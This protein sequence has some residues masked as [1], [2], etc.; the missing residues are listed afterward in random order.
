MAETKPTPR[1]QLVDLSTAASNI[2]PL[3]FGSPKQ[4]KTSSVTQQ[5][6]IDPLARESLM[7]IINTSVSRANNPQEANAVVQDILRRASTAFA[8]VMGESNRTGLY[9]S[10]TL[11]LLRDQAVADAT[12]AGAKAVLDFQTQNQQI[13]ANAAG[14]LAQTTRSVNSQSTENG[15][16]APGIDPAVSLGI[17]GAIAAKTIWN[18]RGEIEDFISGAFGG[19]GSPGGSGSQGASVNSQEAAS[20]ID[21]EADLSPGNFDSEFSSLDNP[22]NFNAFSPTAF[23]SIDTPVGSIGVNPGSVLGAINTVAQS[24]AIGVLGTGFNVAANF[25]NYDPITAAAK[26][27]APFA[28]QAL[29]PGPLGMALNFAVQKGINYISNQFRTRGPFEKELEEYTP[30]DNYE[31][32]VGNYQGSFAGLDGFATAGA[33]GI[34]GQLANDPFGASPASLGINT[35]LSL[36]TY[37]SMVDD[38]NT[39]LGTYGPGVDYGETFGPDAPEGFGAVDYGESF[40]PDN[41][42]SFG[43]VDY[44]ETFG[45]PDPNAGTGESMGTSMDD[46]GSGAGVGENDTTGGGDDSSS[47]DGSIICTELCKQGRLNKRLWVLGTRHFNGYWNYGRR[48]YY[49]WSRPSVQHLRAKPTSS[50]SKFLEKV[51]TLRAEYIASRAGYKNYKPTLSGAAITHGMYVMCWLLAVFVCAPMDVIRRV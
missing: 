28:T 38:I 48:G 1:N 43:S 20:S 19:K 27:V 16:T 29:A 3:L 31:V 33:P 2:I 12:G 40:G 22:S 42:N 32:E 26:S 39:S 10:Q 25:A 50:Y 51:F 24:P 13:A 5:A 7:N 23:G 14:T 9:N 15:K 36:D 49:L 6:S 11:N 34:A 4:T 41:P 18:N 17:G 45:P 35:S 46:V 37:G 47:D 21:D 44:G 8:P 30:F